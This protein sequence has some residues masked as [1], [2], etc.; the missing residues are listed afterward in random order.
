[1]KKI[2][3][4]R[5]QQ[6]FSLI[7]VMLA[8]MLLSFSV[9]GFANA[10]LLAL[11]ATEEAYAINVARLKMVELAEKL[12]R[13]KL[14]PFCLRQVRLQWE[15]EVEESLPQGIGLISE[16]LSIVRSN[17]QWFSHFSKSSTSIALWFSL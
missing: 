5:Y 7:E 1:M 8:A 6:G 17:V 2:T 15:K 10:Q 11:Q 12:K 4:C 9:L 16:H 3:R 13:C 14:Q